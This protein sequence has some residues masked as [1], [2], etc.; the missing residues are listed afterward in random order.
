VEGR[1]D[2]VR[3]VLDKKVV[4]RHGREMGRVDG[5]VIDAG[6]AAP[7]V[8]AIEI[9]SSTLARR[10]ARFLGRWAAGLERALGIDGGRPLRIPFSAV[11]DV[12]D[13]VRVD[14]AVGDTPGAVVE[15]A[16]RD[17]FGSLPRGSK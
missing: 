11:L 9:G 4:D 1:L 14:V 8:A 12:A 17:V 7:R 16:L 6:G 10:V 13:H 5:I 3:D 15:H 2:L